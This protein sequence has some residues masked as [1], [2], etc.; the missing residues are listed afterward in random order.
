MDEAYEKEH[1]CDSCGAVFT[2]KHEVYDDVLYCPF[3]GDDE[4]VSDVDEQE[5]MT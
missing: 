4:L 2:I 3:C 1:T 5:T